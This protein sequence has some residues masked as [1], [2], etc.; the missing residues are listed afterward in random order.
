LG[1]VGFR[2]AGL[3][4]GFRVAGLG[5]VGLGIHKE[6][7]QRMNAKMRAPAVYSLGFTG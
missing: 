2:V 3:G 6:E 7:M 1:G 5:G 4:V